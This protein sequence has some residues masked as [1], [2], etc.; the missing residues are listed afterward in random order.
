[1]SKWLTGV[2]AHLSRGTSPIERAI[3]TSSAP[4]A[5]APK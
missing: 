4:I 1:M 5:D 3:L 2:A